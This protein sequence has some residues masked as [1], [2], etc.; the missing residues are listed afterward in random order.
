MTDP[1]PPQIS[2]RNVLKAPALG[3]VATFLA[4]CS[5]GSSEPSAG[6]AAQ[7]IAIPTPPPATPPA[8]PAAATPVPSPTGRLKFA[9]WPAY[10]DLPGKAYD[11]G[12]YT[13]G[14][15]PTIEKFKQ[16]YGV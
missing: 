8:A 9:K 5:T 6:A 14:S 12:E 11:T 2:R 15:S 4:A 16:K 13:A 10:I 3:G 1:I 7:S